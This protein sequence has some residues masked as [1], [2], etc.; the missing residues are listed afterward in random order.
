VDVQ[1]ILA[2]EF[3]VL[4]KLSSIYVLLP[5]LGYSYLRPRPRHR[6]AD[7]VAQAKFIE[8]LPDT[9]A[10]VAACHPGRR[11][12]I[13]FQDESR[14]RQQGSMTNVWARRGSRPTAVR[15]TE[16]E[17]IWVLGAVCPE[18]GK[19]EGLLSPRLN[20]DVVNIFLKQ[21]SATVPDDEH[22]VIIWDG[23]GYVRPKASYSI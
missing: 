12:R 23:A 1:N 18:T 5:K 4:R 9:L 11:L 2:Q 10:A 8:Q 13:F 3:G 7:P 21:F 22:A 6:K 14:F 17:Y 19:A 20:K 16:Y 15:Q